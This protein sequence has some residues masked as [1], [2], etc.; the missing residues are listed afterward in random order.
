MHAHTSCPVAGCLFEH[1]WRQGE[2]ARALLQ[3]AG[4]VEVFTARD[5][6]QRERASGGDLASS[7][8]VDED[9]V[10]VGMQRRVTMK[11]CMPRAKA[12]AHGS[13]VDTQN[14]KDMPMRKPIVVRLLPGRR[15]SGLIHRSLLCALAWPC[16]APLAFAQDAP[17]TSPASAAS[18]DV[19]N[20]P[21]DR[22]KGAPRSTSPTQA[23]ALG[24]V[25]V[26]ANR[27][28]EPSREVPMH[29]DTIRADE[30][31]QTG[32]RTLS[33]YASYEPGVFFASQGGSGRA[34]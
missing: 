26:T 15:L 17:A 4:Y 34:S 7:L 2:A 1:G 23:V 9:D 30:L 31:R 11:T 3:T 24:E 32:A 18:Q 6:E 22:R 10:I 12:A 27:R 29:V 16:L 25:M 19:Q 20:A 28:R 33:D 13:T 8:A 5:L 21:G 14:N